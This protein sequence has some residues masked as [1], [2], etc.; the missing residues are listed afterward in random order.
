MYQ[1]KS[2]I[3]QP[4]SH[5]QAVRRDSQASA[6]EVG[7]SSS[8]LVRFSKIKLLLGRACP[9][10][11]DIVTVRVEDLAMGVRLPVDRCCRAIVENSLCVVVA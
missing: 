2:R 7:R 8:S 9:R 10:D 5:E 4:T 6:F 11:D 1:H 3:A